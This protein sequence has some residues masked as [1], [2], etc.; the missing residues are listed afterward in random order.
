MINLEWL[1]TF[2]S[3]YEHNNITEASR[4][5]NMTQPGVSKHL[6]ALENHIGK[7]LFDRTTRKLTPTEYG[8]FLYSQIS[9][10][11]EQLQKVERY[12]GK[13][14]KKTRS[15]ISIGCTSD[16]FSSD[17][18]DK[19]YSL[20]MYVATA[21]GTE[22]ELI[23][24]L[25]T[26]NFQLLIGT[27]RYSVYD[28]LFTKIRSEELIL[29]GSSSISIPS[30]LEND[31]DQ[32]IGWLQKQTW[33]VYDNDQSDLKKF[34]KAVFDRIPKVV[35]RY[36]LPSYQHIVES[37]KHNDGVSIVPKRSCENE[38]GRGLV[39]ELFKASRPVE[40]NLYYSCKSKNSNLS[41]INQFM[42]KINSNRLEDSEV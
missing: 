24:G 28:H 6:L 10:P 16:F 9:N 12:S 38:I 19:I 20:D 27:K 1:R 37:I 25:E 40:R 29:I 2:G 36:I 30:G 31:I 17:L 8:K 7:K 15:A 39:N 4:Q 13:R 34:Y 11:L 14:V 18:I 32:L 41:E 23:E 22:K 26:E 21:F 33:F 3:I 42:D 35:P 5:L